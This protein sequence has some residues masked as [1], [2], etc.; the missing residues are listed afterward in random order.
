MTGERS[1]TLQQ[2]AFHNISSSRHPPPSTIRR[3][4]HTARVAPCIARPVERFRVDVCGAAE[5]A[6]DVVFPGEA[7]LSRERYFSLSPSNGD[8]GAGGE[9]DFGEAVGRVTQDVYQPQTQEYPCSRPSAQSPPNPKVPTSP[10]PLFSPSK[11]KFNVKSRDLADTF[12][13]CTLHL[14]HLPVT[15]APVTALSFF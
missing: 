15:A 12:L 14:L 10:L 4:R 8:V 13:L 3:T 2:R 9:T 11:I 7:E 5:P 6:V 1:Y